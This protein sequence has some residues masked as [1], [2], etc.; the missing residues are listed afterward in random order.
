MSR[1]KW[2][3]PLIWGMIIAILNPLG[4][5][6]IALI[7]VALGNTLTFVWCAMLA[8]AI[9]FYAIYLLCTRPH[10]SRLVQIYLLM[11]GTLMLP[12]GLV[13]LITCCMNEIKA[14]KPRSSSS[15]RETKDG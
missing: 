7:G 14:I 13:L 5:S 6:Y 8:W 11:M 15:Q 1:K 4:I 9:Y 3:Q 10:E 2:S 12:W